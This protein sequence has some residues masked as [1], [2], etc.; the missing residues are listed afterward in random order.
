[1]SPLKVNRLDSPLARSAG[2][3]Q[4]RAR[5]EKPVEASRRSTPTGRVSEARP[6]VALES[7]SVPDA[8]EISPVTAE[9]LLEA[10]PDPP[11][12]AE[13]LELLS[14]RLPSSLRRQVS[15][16]TAA[17]RGRDGG[18]VSQKA[19]PEQEVLAVLIWLAGSADDPDAIRR[20][21]H[22]LDAYRARRYA[23]E[24]RALAG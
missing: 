18:R 1:M 23:A 13:T 15:D 7:V 16:F 21:S 14:T 17:L 19:L 4:R 9:S 2:T 24:A 8:D 20:L 6:Q 22:A 10:L 3:D 11:P 5:P 12:L